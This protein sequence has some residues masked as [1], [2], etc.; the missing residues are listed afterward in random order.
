MVTYSKHSCVAFLVVVTVSNNV[1]EAVKVRHLQQSSD[2]TNSQLGD[3][4]SE[5]LARINKERAAAGLSPLCFNQKLQYASQSHSDDMAQN[6]FMAHVG[7]DGSSV[8]QRITDVGFAWNKVAENVAAGQESVQ[9]VIDAWMLSP[10]HR[11]NIMG[12]WKWKH[13]IV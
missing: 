7:S 4:R 10:K 6:A 2:V 13:G 12:L 8:A 1:S 11:E 5:M 3:Y 9:S